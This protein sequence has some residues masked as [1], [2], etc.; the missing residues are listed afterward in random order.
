M[1]DA[2]LAARQDYKLFWDLTPCEISKILKSNAKNDRSD[3]ELQRILNHEFAGLIALAFHDP[4]KMQEYK[5]L[6]DKNTKSE[7]A[8]EN[9]DEFLKSKM[10]KYAAAFGKIK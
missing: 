3:F 9:P 4:S 1:L 5:P 8:V 2:W 6:I 7:V 10:I